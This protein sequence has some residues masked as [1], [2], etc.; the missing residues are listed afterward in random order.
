MASGIHE[1]ET[2]KENQVVVVD[3]DANKK[4]TP[5]SRRRRMGTLLEQDGENGTKYC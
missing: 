2:P 1:S 5:L 3:D 4:A